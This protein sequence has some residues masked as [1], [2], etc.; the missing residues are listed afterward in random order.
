MTETITLD[1]DIFYNLKGYIAKKYDSEEKSEI[2]A[3]LTLF[4]KAIDRGK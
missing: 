3:I 1:K 4:K 2:K